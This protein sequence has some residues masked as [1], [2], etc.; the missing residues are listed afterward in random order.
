MPEQFLDRAQVRPPFQHVGSVSVPQH[1]RRRVGDTRLPTILYNEPANVRSRKASSVVGHQQRSLSE[2]VSCRPCA[3][4]QDPTAMG[5]IAAEGDTCRRSDRHY[6]RSAALAANPQLLPACLEV[7]H[8]QADGLLAP[9]AAPVEQFQ[10]EPVPQ[11][12]GVVVS[13]RGQDRFDFGECE[14]ARQPAGAART[15]QLPRGVCRKNAL[16]REVPQQPSQRRQLAGQGGRR[17]PT[18]PQVGREGPYLA[19]VEVIDRVLPDLEPIQQLVKVRLIGAA[20]AGTGATCVELPEVGGA[21]AVRVSMVLP[22]T[23]RVM[24]CGRLVR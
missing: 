17:V 15:R 14:D 9:Q 11:C 5:E 16:L 24:A 20:G 12:Q 2:P 13:R 3:G 6:P 8:P 22:L 18:P 10:D 19:A 1:V 23:A 4:Q 21:A 7:F